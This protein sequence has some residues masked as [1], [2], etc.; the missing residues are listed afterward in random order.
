MLMRSLMPGSRRKWGKRS[1]WPRWWRS[2]VYA[3][4]A[5]A[6]L[7]SGTVAGIC[8]RIHVQNGR[9][10]ITGLLYQPEPTSASRILVLAPHPDDET[11]GCGGLLYNAARARAAIRVVFVTNGDGFHLAAQRACA[12]V[13]V[14][15]ADFVRLGIQRQSEARAALRRLGVAEKDATFLGY[16]DRGVAHLWLECWQPGNAYTSPYTKTAA[17]PYA[18]VYRAQAPHSGTGLL[19]DLER[20]VRDFR[21]TEVYVPHPNDEHADHWATSCFARAAI[22][23]LG[24]AERTA[25]YTYLVHRGDWPVPQGLHPARGLAPP[26]ARGRRG[27]VRRAQPLT[28]PR[29]PANEPARGEHRSQ[30][31]VMRRFLTSFLRQTELFGAISAAQVR[32][33]PTGGVRVDGDTSEWGAIEWRAVQPA[34]EE[35]TGDSLPVRVGGGADIAAIRVCRDDRYL[36]VLLSSRRQISKRLTYVLHLRTLDGDERSL[37]IA[38]RPGKSSTQSGA[39]VATRGQ[40]IETAVPL[41]RLGGS[42]ILFI[43]AS[44][45]TRG[46]SIDS[47][48][49]RVLRLI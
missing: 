47:T 35:P 43:G 30:M 23:R 11:L 17:I 34:V 6:L 37:A 8:F 21:P 1:A 40:Y 10:S 22:E 46:F 5:L 3:S 16:P 9:E 49:W 25:V 29:L 27:N 31:V 4:F 18:D 33:A 14:R 41:S 38:I 7:L 36:Y 13:R 45:R 20:I 26:A 19:A 48:G 32:A 44:A 12:R 2:L 28:S 39:L 42:Q 24:I 15:P